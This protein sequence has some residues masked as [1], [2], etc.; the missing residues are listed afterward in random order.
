MTQWALF[1]ILHAQYTYIKV[2]VS[3]SFQICLVLVSYS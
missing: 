2:V 1:Y 3:R